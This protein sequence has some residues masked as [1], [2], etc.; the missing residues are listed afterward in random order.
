MQE[1][2]TVYFSIMDTMGVV[3]IEIG[4]SVFKMIE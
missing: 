1:K 4:I 2:G 3:R